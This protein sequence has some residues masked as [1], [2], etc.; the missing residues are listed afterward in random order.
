LKGW[1]M[2]IG[3]EEAYNLGIEMSCAYF[4]ASPDVIAAYKESLNTPVPTSDGPATSDITVKWSADPSRHLEQIMTQKWLALFPDGL[5]AWGDIRRNELPKLLPRINSENPDVG[6]NDIMRRVLYV[7]GEYNTNKEE[8]DKA[9]QM[10]GG[11][12][13]GNTRLWWNPAK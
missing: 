12:D 9:I 6:V 2:G 10:N 1:N 5:E 7:P 3:A 13:K 4:G 11:P 8:L